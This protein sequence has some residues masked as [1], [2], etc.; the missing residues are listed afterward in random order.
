M[1]NMK[2]IKYRVN[3]ICTDRIGYKIKLE[4]FKLEVMTQFVTPALESWQEDCYTV[5]ASQDYVVI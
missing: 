4:V 5:E 2:N 3:F 1:N